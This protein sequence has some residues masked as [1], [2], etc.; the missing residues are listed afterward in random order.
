MSGVYIIAEAGVNH[1]GDIELAKE[2][3]DIAAHA[4]ADAV[5][6]QTFKAERLITPF[7]PKAEYQLLTTDASESQFEMIRCLELDRDTHKELIRYC[8]SKNIEFLSSPFDIESIELLAELNLK[9]IKIPSGEITNLPYL[10]KIGSLKKEVILSTGMSTLEEIRSA[11]HVL[12]NAGIHK[13]QIIVLHCSTAYVCPYEDVNLNAMLA[14]RDE[15][16]VK[17]GYSDHSK[18]IEVPIAAVAIGAEVIEKHFTLNRKLSGPDHEASLEPNELMAMIR[19]IR[20][21]EIA[22]GS[23]VKFPFP[24]EIQNKPMV[25]KSIVASA[26][27]KKGDVLT[28]ENITTKRPGYGISPMKWDEVIGTQAIKDFDVDELVEL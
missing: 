16:D 26:K 25:R 2:L 14:I 1:N 22:L 9:I 6:F 8:S 20:N 13:D 3:V 17:V 10:R 5:K 21:I 24:S 4:G 18:G 19:A 27:I 23:R 12:T 11:L 28:E 7:A 15:F